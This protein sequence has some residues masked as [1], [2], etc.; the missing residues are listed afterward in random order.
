MVS[1]PHTRFVAILLAVL[2]L[3]YFGLV[4]M[5]AV[6]L[7]L[8]VP[9][10]LG[11]TYNSMTLR[12]LEGRFDVDPAAIG[13]EGFV[14]DGRTYSYFGIF[15]ALLRLP[16]V[17]FIDLATVLVEGTY[18]YAASLLAASGG[19]AMVVTLQRHF[20]PADDVATRPLLIA[21]ALSGP[22]VMLAIRPG[23]YQEA[24]LWA[25]GLCAWFLAILLPALRAGAKPSAG[26]LCALALLSGLCL[27]TRPTTGL[28]LM[29][30]LG[31]LLL[32]MVLGEATKDGLTGSGLL[33][34]AIRGVLRGEIVLPV[35][36]VCS[37]GV[38]AA[39]V[40]L[41]RW[42]NPF[43]FADVRLQVALVEAYP[44]RL[45]RLARYGLFHPER[46]GL[47]VL[48]Y[49][50]P[51]WAWNKGERFLFHDDVVRLFDAFELPPSSFFLTDPLTMLLAAAGFVALL[52]GRLPTFERA[53]VFAV[54]A[55]FSVAPALMLVGWYMAFR[56]RA[57]FM[58]LF[59]LGACLG[60]ISIGTAMARAAPRR[61]AWA[62]GLLWVLLGL[63]LIS[64][65]AHAL[66]YAVSPYGPAHRF[67]GEGLGTIYL[68]RAPSR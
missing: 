33:R 58:P 6:G 18:R 12:L 10:Q 28:G 5:A 54:V 49:F 2:P 55:G 22:S 1:G 26:R 51:I 41:A 29:L 16:L 62:G 56:Y 47:G 67:A 21:A 53:R 4:S 7:T 42:G 39:G 30:G 34:R 25:W 3:H 20:G 66:I 38:V 36:V 44:D 64:A 59:L 61:R 40:N 15:P 57:E 68:Q 24:A 46:F 11:L 14:R 45:D 60:A 50:L 48:Y 19:V 9:S 27:L 31:L 43:V 13:Y 23:I 32:S 65:H 37:L 63:Q 8:D 17:P 35:L 52:R